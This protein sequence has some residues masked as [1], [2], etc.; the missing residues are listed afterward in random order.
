MS[1]CEMKS[2]IIHIYPSLA[3]DSDGVC[4][5]IKNLISYQTGLGHTVFFGTINVKFQNNEKNLFLSAGSLIKWI[6]A[7]FYNRDKDMT[8]IH[9]HGFWRL[10]PL[11]FVLTHKKRNSVI[12]FSP[13]GMLMKGSLERSPL[14][15]KIF[16]FIFLDLI[17]K[18]CDLLIF[19]SDI[20]RLS[21]NFSN[22][23]FK[24]LP[25]G[26]N[27]PDLFHISQSQSNKNFLY[28]GRID[29]RKN[30]LILLRAWGEVCPQLPD[31]SLS[32]VGAKGGEYYE[33]CVN[34]V[35]EKKLLNVKFFDEVRNSEV[36]NVFR[37]AS[38]L[39]L[40]SKDESFGL[41][42]AES[43]AHGVPVIVSVSSPWATIVDGA[44]GFSV[45]ETQTDLEKYLVKFAGLPEHLRA[46]M[47]ERG[48]SIIANSF[49]WQIAGA[50]Y[51][52]AYDEAVNL[53][54][55]KNG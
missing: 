8:I 20:E 41:V 34:F 10:L 1:K 19:N 5:V 55:S 24:V 30:V 33:R 23:S 39:V 45:S 37:D 15:K 9:L 47:A 51:Q 14:R 38:A 18:K 28:L 32:I 16:S 6:F 42:V 54:A 25:N 48:R 40:I 13:H 17:L 22:N 52:S 11:L 4:T 36:F 12:I 46:D 26:T 49:S 27:L 7:N 43:L 53:S 3:R 31:W 29:P 35:E 21:S 50:K 2:R 44:C